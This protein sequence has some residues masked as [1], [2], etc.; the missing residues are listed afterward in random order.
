MCAS[1][2][3]ILPLI[4]V[5]VSGSVCLTQLPHPDPGHSDSVWLP[6]DGGSDHHDGVC[7]KDAP[8]DQELWQVQRPVEEGEGHQRGGPAPGRGGMG[9]L[10]SG[11]AHMGDECQI[12]FL[13]SLCP[14]LL[15]STC[16]P[17]KTSEG[18]KE[19]K[20]GNNDQRKRTC[21]K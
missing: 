11:W 21:K 1:F 5:V 3:R 14:L 4:S 19:R 20:C 6:G 7:L 15:S 17:H 12:Y 18:S 9:E 8:E 16:I 10:G 2:R 13:N